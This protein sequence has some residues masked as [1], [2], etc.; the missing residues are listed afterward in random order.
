MHVDGAE[1]A[2]LASVTL[3]NFLRRK[4]GH[5]Y[6]PSKS[7]DFEDDQHTVVNGLWRNEEPLPSVEPTR[8]KNYTKYAGSVR[9]RFADY[10]LQKEGE[11]EWQYTAAFN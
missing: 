11:V 2:V 6:M 4:C 8:N 7:I 9:N 10:F 1:K 5:S 3:H